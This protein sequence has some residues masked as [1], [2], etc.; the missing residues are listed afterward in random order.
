MTEYGNIIDGDTEKNYKQII[1]AFIENFKIRTHNLNAE[2]L[3]SFGYA[4]NIST[5]D[6]LYFWVMDII[7]GD[8][9]KNFHSIKRL[10]NNKELQKFYEKKRSSASLL[11]SRKRGSRR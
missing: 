1:P 2:V 6:G 4:H 11:L 7:E 8:I 9:S 10:I 3:G 5:Q